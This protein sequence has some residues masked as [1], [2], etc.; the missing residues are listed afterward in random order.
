MK[1]NILIPHFN[2][3]EEYPRTHVMSLNP[4]QLGSILV[5]LR[6]ISELVTYD[7]GVQEAAVLGA[8][9]VFNVFYID[10]VFEN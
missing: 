2:R 8:N 1:E 3:V 5:E 9:L 10:R 7:I 6:V 4:K